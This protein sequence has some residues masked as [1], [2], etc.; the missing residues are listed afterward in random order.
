[1]ILSSILFFSL[2]I[3]SYAQQ[4]NFGCTN[5]APCNLICNPNFDYT[6]TGC[7]PPNNNNSIGIASGTG[8]CKYPGWRGLIN[9]PDYM[10]SGEIGMQTRKP[11]SPTRS[12]T[13]CT[14]AQINSG[15]YYLLSYKARNLGNYNSNVQFKLSQFAKLSDNTLGSNFKQ[16]INNA[17]TN[18]NNPVSYGLVTQTLNSIT[19]STASMQQV[20]HSF[21][22]YKNYDLLSFEGYIGN[23]ASGDPYSY[24]VFDEFELIS[25]NGEVI[26]A[27]KG[28]EY[29]VNE[30]DVPSSVNNFSLDSTST[31]S[32]ANSENVI[33]LRSAKEQYA[34][35]I[36]L[37][38][39]EYKI[40]D[41][42]C[43]SDCIGMT[44]EEKAEQGFIL[45]MTMID[46]N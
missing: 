3:S 6:N 35:N 39:K 24:V 19:V 25:V 10:I 31:I 29:L 18:N 16:K 38:F 9:T 17:I 1:M 34:K 7:I 36:G 28:W 20:V 8:I 41:T 13:I 27:F 23:N 43:I 46:Y 40:L 26:E 22:A 45:R 5:T 30:L 21:F 12:E 33:E 4:A 15:S 32:Y 14:N 2:S 37:I 42:Q 44:W 11:S